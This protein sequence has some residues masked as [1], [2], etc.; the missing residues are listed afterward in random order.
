MVRSEISRYSSYY[1][2]LSEQAEADLL[3]HFSRNLEM[4]SFCVTAT[5]DPDEVPTVKLL[6]SVRGGLRHEGC[7]ICCWSAGPWLALRNFNLCSSC[8]N[9]L[10][11]LDHRCI[12]FESCSAA[13]RMDDLRQV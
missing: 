7:L 5:M 11:E 6:L 2:T 9:S 1:S 12:R 13:I 4:L 8:E 10:E 3:P